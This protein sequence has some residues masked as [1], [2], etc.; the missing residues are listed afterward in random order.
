MDDLRKQVDELRLRK[1]QDE[2]I[3]SMK[4]KEIEN[5]KNNSGPAPSV[6]GG[7]QQELGFQPDT[8]PSFNRPL[9][10]LKRPF[11][12]SHTIAISSP[13]TQFEGHIL[14]SANSAK[15]IWGSDFGLFSDVI[16]QV[17][18]W[19]L[20]N[21]TQSKDGR[22]SPRPNAPL[23]RLEANLEL[24]LP[25]QQVLEIQHRLCLH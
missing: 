3:I 5:L 22:K 8:E 1:M 4:S 19:L 10:K 7:S 24:H 17:T 16:S 6:Y 14:T 2:M 20:V 21:R 15:S 11:I 13:A 9:G 25:S 18:L 23:A 12:R